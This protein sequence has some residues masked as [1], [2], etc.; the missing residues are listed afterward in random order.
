MPR[1]ISNTT[2]N[3]STID[4]LNVIR[5]NASLEYQN[6]VPEITQ[7]TDIPAVGEVL[8][9]YPAL[10]NQFINALVNRIALVRVES[11]TFNNPYAPLKK[12]YLEY[13][14]TVEEIFVNIAKVFVFSEEKAEARELKRYLP[15]VRAA[16]HVINWRVLY[17]VTIEEEQLRQ[18]FLSIDGVQDLIA[19]IVDSV[20]T[21]A[22]YDEFLLFKYLII[23]AVNKGKMY[24]VPIVISDLKNAATGFRGVSNLL[25][26]MSSKY[27]EARVKN[28]TPK[29]RQVI[30]MD[31][32]FNASF[33][34]NVLASAF[35]MD[36]ADFMGRL[37]LID[38]F[39]TFDN[40]RWDVIRS[41]S[42]GLEEVT[43][44]ELGIMGDVIAVLGDE[45]WFQLYDNLSKFAEKYVASGLRWNY[46]YHVWKTISTSPYHNMIVFVKST[47][48]TGTPTAIT[49]T[50]QSTD[51]DAS[52]NTVL[53]L[54]IT[55]ITGGTA[56]TFNNF[57]L[58]QTESAV[59]AGVAIQPYGSI[60]IPSTATGT[61]S[62]T[63]EVTDGVTTMEITKTVTQLLALAP[64]STLA[65][66]PASES[67]SGGGGTE[68]GGTEGGGGTP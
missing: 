67:G 54:D 16:F 11:A 65:F 51:I 31:A 57:G 25:P 34:V 21:A 45:T 60:I 6:N 29:D 61:D 3:A 22:E 55:S 44:T 18:A 41:E 49:Y 10:A 23:K 48:S 39:T 24:P 38:D 26:F 20:Y 32:M 50:V 28:T 36:R 37:H 58:V 7:A 46:F 30:F 56:L 35:N 63:L 5:Q 13:G 64:G 40:E 19:R 12:G 47:A 9:G 15:D 14:E 8:M 17:P 59:E 4:I 33:D 66:E 1:R 52:G 27:N 42:T 68:G 62:V 2:L 53:N 43:S